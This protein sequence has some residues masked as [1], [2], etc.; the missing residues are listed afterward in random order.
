MLTDQEFNESLES[1][2]GSDL[3]RMH[4]RRD[5]DQRLVDFSK[6]IL[7]SIGKKMF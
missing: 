7:V 4:S 6:V 1:I 2:A 3:S 5:K